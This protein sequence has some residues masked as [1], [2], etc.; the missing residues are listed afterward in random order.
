MKRDIHKLAAWLEKVCQEG[1][2]IERKVWEWKQAEEEKGKWPVLS[3]ADVPVTDDQ[4]LQ[5]PLM[6]DVARSGFDTPEA[7]IHLFV[8]GSE[9]HGAKVGATDDLDIYGVFLDSPA[10]VLGLKPRSHFVWSTA[11][12][13]R[14]NGPD[15][16]DIT[17]YS[18]HRWAEL[19]AKGNATALH[20]LFADAT[21]TSSGIWKMIQQDRGFFLSKESASQFLGFADNQLQRITGERGRGAKGRRLE[22][23]NAFGYDSKAAMHCLRLYLECIELMRF[24]TITL[25]RPDR[26]LLIEVRSGK[27]TLER[28]LG[29]AANLRSEAEK[30]A[31]QSA[32][33]E[34]VDQLSISRLIAKVCFAAWGADKQ[35]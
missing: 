22:Y 21:A 34:R 17:L 27:W 4:M 32:L 11:S 19:A 33:P 29:E 8:G 24:G 9:L 5:T 7:I 2:A 15:D 12:D 20:F 31:M 6:N 28:F 10:D 3:F 26:E 1:V 30:A 35:N 25:P 23:E 13:E 18:L 14:R 16:V